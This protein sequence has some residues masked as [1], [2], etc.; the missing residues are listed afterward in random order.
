MDGQMSASDCRNSGVI[1]A[2]PGQTQHTDLP[3]KRYYIHVIIEDTG[4]ASMLNT[5]EDFICRLIPVNWNQ[6]FLL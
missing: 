3:H 1:C 2:K 6:H 4:L 5:I